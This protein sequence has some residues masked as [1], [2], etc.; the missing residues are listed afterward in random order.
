MNDRILFFVGVLAL[1]L[2][3][4]TTVCCAPSRK[5]TS[6]PPISNTAEPISSTPAQQIAATVRVTVTCS[7][8]STWNGSGVRVTTTIMLTAAHVANA[9]T[10]HGQATAFIVTVD[11]YST[12]HIAA[13]I[14]SWGAYD[15]AALFTFDATPTAP[16]EFGPYPGDGGALCVSV[17]APKRDRRCADDAVAGSDARG[18]RFKIRSEPGNSGS[19]VYDSRGRLVGLMIE[20]FIIS[21]DGFAARLD[22]LDGLQELLA[23]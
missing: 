4:T 8:G 19:G 17:A 10:E 21:S 2:A 7:D 3:V 23:R 1:V 11:P 18:F 15:V 22:K 6:T 12:I 13:L 5:S 20:Y 9:C 16:I 14:R